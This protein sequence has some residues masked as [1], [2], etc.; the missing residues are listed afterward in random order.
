MT[1]AGRVVA[2][3]LA[4]SMLSIGPAVAADPSA[5]VSD[6]VVTATKMVEEL[7][8]M[9]QIRCL[10]PE[11]GVERAERPRVVSSFP[12]QGAVVRPGLLIVRMTFNQPITCDGLFLANPPL[13]NPCPEKPQKM[14]LS[15]DRRTVRTLC[16]VAPNTHYGL[17][18]NRDLSGKVFT[19]LSGLPSESHEFNFTTS[20]EAPLTTV[21]D[22]LVEDSVGAREILSQRKLN[23][24]DASASGG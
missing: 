7:T 17:L 11:K 8:V 19:G 23:C 21:C 16:V 3:G 10:H 18:T 22:A 13:Q 4:T 14:L 15:Y 5:S 12:E 9:A 6:V 1:L 2:I 20:A 24:R